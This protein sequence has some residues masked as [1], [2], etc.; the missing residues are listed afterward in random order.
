MRPQ[1]LGGVLHEIEGDE[2]GRRPVCS[3]DNRLQMAVVFGAR[4]WPRQV[5][6]VACRRPWSFGP[7]PL[8]VPRLCTRR[9]HDRGSY[10]RSSQAQ[11]NTAVYGY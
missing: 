11:R 6:R 3:S 4:L 5:V 7:R 2:S 10:L 9:S 8:P 1:V